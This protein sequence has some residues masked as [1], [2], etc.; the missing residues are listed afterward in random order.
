[1]VNINS[2]PTRAR[3]KQNTHSKNVPIVPD[4]ARGYILGPGRRFIDLP[5]T[6]AK[7]ERESAI[8][9][10]RTQLRDLSPAA[11]RLLNAVLK[12]V[13]LRFDESSGYQVQPAS[14]AVIAAQLGRKSLI[15]HDIKLLRELV[16]LD[17][18]TEGRQPLPRRQVGQ[19]WHG[20]GYEYVYSIKPD[21]LICLLALDPV[22]RDRLR[23]MKKNAGQLPTFTPPEPEKLPLLDRIIDFF[24]NNW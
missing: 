9:S 4:A 7:D 21:T 11:A 1:M 6:R 17:L 24:I 23:E 13:L 18:V 8:R 2:Q 15:P 14:R 19:I 3:T 5:D 22:E 16:F 10:M 20:A 12:S